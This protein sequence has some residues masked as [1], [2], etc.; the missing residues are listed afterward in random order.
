MRAK[1]KAKAL[2]KTEPF[3]VQAIAT[4]RRSWERSAPGCSPHNAS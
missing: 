3:A 2:F 1:A 4:Q